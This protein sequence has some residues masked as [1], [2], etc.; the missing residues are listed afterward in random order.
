MSLDSSISIPFSLDSLGATVSFPEQGRWAASSTD[1]EAQSQSRLPSSPPPDED[2]HFSI[3]QPSRQQKDSS[4]TSTQNVFVPRE[5]LDSDMSL[6]IKAR[7]EERNFESPLQTSRSLD[8]IAENSSLSSTALLDARRLLSQAE[9]VVSAESSTASSV[10]PAVTRLL[11]DGDVY[12][13]LGKKTTRL[14][15]PSLFSFSAAQ[16]PRTGFSFQGTRSSSD[17]MLTSEKPRQS[18]VSRESV[19]SSTQLVT[20]PAADTVPQGGTRGSSLILTE[21]ARRA[22]PEG[23]SAAPP[24][25]NA[26]PPPPVI[27]PLSAVATQQST[28][29]PSAAAEGAEDEEKIPVGGPAQGNSSPILDNTDQGVVSDGSSESSL[30]VR[31]AKLLQSESPSTMVSSSASITDQ[32]ES[33]ARGINVDINTIY[34][35]LVEGA[36][37]TAYAT[38]I[39]L[40]LHK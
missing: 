25:S 27:K 10:T 21:P 38:N 29:A 12:L 40:V 7:C 37:L 1:T 16:E 33:K 11:S 35:H 17:S 31:V 34:L 4:L 28:S 6:G 13:S 39:F 5:R 14:H 15:D 22:E 8:Q 26:P 23:C 9:N 24:D 19:T 3:P 2:S 36:Y 30:A 20:A 32:E 18:F